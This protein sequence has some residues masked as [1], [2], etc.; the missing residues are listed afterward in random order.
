MKL[1]LD[2]VLF[3]S[4]AVIVK[5]NVGY[6]TPPLGDSWNVWEL[7]KTHPADGKS[8]VMVQVTSIGK[9]V[10]LEMPNVSYSVRYPE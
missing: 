10:G 1:A 4:V 8:S 5:A 3:S 6:A 9:V 7:S 2:G